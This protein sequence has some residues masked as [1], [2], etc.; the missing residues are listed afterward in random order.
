MLLE[1]LR[2]PSAQGHANQVRREC[3]L[4]AASSRCSNAPP[5]PFRATHVRPTP[6]LSMLFPPQVHHGLQFETGGTFGTNWGGVVQRTR[7]E[8]CSPDAVISL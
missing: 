2:V 8:L 1:M 6:V 4:D 3:C 5:R 7:S